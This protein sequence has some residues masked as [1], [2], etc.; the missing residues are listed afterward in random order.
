MSTVLFS[1]S[2]P[3]KV[4]RCVYPVF[5]PSLNTSGSSKRLMENGISDGEEGVLR[6]KGG[7]GGRGKSSVSEVGCEGVVI[8]KRY[9]PTRRGLG[10]SGVSSIRC[11]FLRKKTTS[12]SEINDWES[13]L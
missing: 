3:L 10:V 12:F 7:I 13:P 2:H 1:D 11:R 5:T 4:L 6:C 9:H 8:S